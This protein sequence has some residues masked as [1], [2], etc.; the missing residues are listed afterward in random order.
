MTQV[1]QTLPERIHALDVG[2][3]IGDVAQDRKA[4]RYSRFVHA[5]K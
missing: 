5:G 4:L 2:V 3:F 1:G